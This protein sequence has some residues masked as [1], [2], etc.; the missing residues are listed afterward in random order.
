MKK[1]LLKLLDSLLKIVTP[2]VYLCLWYA[3]PTI[4]F[5]KENVDVLTL[6]ISALPV[7]FIGVIS[8]QTSWSIGG[9]KGIKGDNI[10]KKVRA[11]IDRKGSFELEGIEM[12]DKKIENVIDSVSKNPIFTNKTRQEG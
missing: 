8:R 9:E 2:L 11:T 6:T 5:G 7:I 1:D 12:D 4:I 10:G 3:I